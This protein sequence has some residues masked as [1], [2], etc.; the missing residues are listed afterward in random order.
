MVRDKAG[1]GSRDHPLQALEITFYLR[2][3]RN[4]F[5]VATEQNGLN[6]MEGRAKVRFKFKV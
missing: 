2:V 3:M 4:H 6:R 1:R 5:I